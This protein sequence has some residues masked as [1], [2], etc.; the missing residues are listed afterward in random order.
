MGF[1]LLGRFEN[2]VSNL[3]TSKSTGGLMLWTPKGKKAV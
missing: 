3:G 2:D 1:E